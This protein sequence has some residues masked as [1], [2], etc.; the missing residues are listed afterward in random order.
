MR[1]RELTVRGFRS[2]ADET[3]FDFSGRT[4]IGIVGPIG[5]GK[6]SILDAV[7]FA[8]YGKTPRVEG[9]TKS[10]IN[11]R[12]DAL[13]VA[14]VF[15]VDG[16]RWRAVRALR[17]NGASAHTLYRVDE[18]GEH[19]VADKAREVTERIT[20]LLGMEF[21][22]FRRSVL[23][24]QNQFAAFLDATG[25]ERNQVL[26]GVFGFDRLDSMRDI[27]RGRLDVIGMSLQHLA[28]RRASAEA[29]RRRLETVS[30]DLVAVDARARTLEGLRESV[31][32]AEAALRTAAAGVAAA[33]E[34]IK[35]LDALGARIPAHA[36]TAAR[37][38]AA[39]GAGQRLAIAEGAVAASVAAVGAAVAAAEALVAERGGTSALEAAGDAVTR[40]EALRG[41]SVAAV[42][43]AERA[44]A[45][46]VAAEAQAA[47][48]RHSLTT[49]TEAAAAASVVAASAAATATEV[50][51]RLHAAHEAD[52]AAAIRAT[53]QRGEPCPVCSQVVSEIPSASGP[54]A[55]APIEQE[56]AAAEAA[57]GGGR[58]ALAAAESQVAAAQ[59]RVVVV[60][61][62]APGLAAAAA[63]ATAEAAATVAAVSALEADL[64]SRLGAG[65][66][67][68]LLADVRARIAE[69]ERAVRGA[70]A[71]EA[72]ARK[73][74]D[75]AA[76][77][78]DG[79]RA[80]LDRLRTELA[81]IAG[82]IG[83]DLDFGDDASTVE[84]GL[85]AL[86]SD[87]LQRHAAATEA[88][89][90]AGREADAARAARADL[91]EKAGLAATDDIVEITTEAMRERTALETEIR[92][93]ERNLAELQGLG[94]EEA[95][96]VSRR[97]L[98]DRLHGDLAPSKFLEFVLDERR[99]V[100]ADLAGVHFETLSAG[101]YRFSDDGEF[102]VVDL[103]AADQV[104][105]A[106]SLSG[107]ESFLASLALALALAE[108]VAREGSRLD[109][110]FLDEGF[111]S[112][113]AEHLDLA[114]DGVERLV[115]AG[116]DRLVVVVSHVP[117][118]RERFE[119]LI[120][121]D[122]DTVTGVTRVVSGS[123]VAS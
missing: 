86:R 54:V 46:A 77:D 8:L 68:Q 13:H 95:A 42:D 115:A 102:D 60:E 41:G 96:A 31:M 21:E 35:G 97:T 113:D 62:R 70:R 107:G 61:E 40:L 87:W 25:T 1:P 9:A 114:I 63:D 43:R 20:A 121:L 117:A 110:F 24:A 75:A 12:R 23:L 88:G 5:S 58:E 76:A 105:P 89:T 55:L 78:R 45:E 18:D 98:L 90:M 103:A 91:M 48:A 65:D 118:L 7:C 69:A 99:R 26:K 66:P 71:A 37:F 28:A 39:T 106:T 59:A 53:L 10:L 85:K 112:L 74:R 17:R 6:S 49:V 52:R 15:D 16:V 56:A 50:R 72:A 30:K 29:D 73:E 111:G 120:V 81:T 64:A 100:L 101:R 104:R 80:G 3:T 57:A 123:G 109:S 84:A 82:R 94:A 122:R 36:D 33:S 47:T 83:V 14:L 4:L 34:E 93:L 79:A 27:A 108:I 51:A 92:L 11:Q 32:Q 2:F 38:A 116:G 22:A 19:E 67:A 44:R 119:D